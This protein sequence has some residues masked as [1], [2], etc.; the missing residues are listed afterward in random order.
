[1]G[2]KRDYPRYNH[3]QTRLSDADYDA[4]R[5]FA[6]PHRISHSKAAE[7][8]IVHAIKLLGVK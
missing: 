6:R 1:M 5:E 8:L 3:V 2:A 4:M 7:Q